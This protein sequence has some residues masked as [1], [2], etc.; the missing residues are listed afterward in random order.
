MADLLS[1][2]L[3]APRLLSVDTSAPAQSAVYLTI[4][5][6]FTPFI[7]PD[8]GAAGNPN[9]FEYSPF[10]MASIIM[11]NVFGLGLAAFS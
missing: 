3:A 10:L 1:I 5:I 11:T 9:I 4:S 8:R 7:P 2:Y 6:N